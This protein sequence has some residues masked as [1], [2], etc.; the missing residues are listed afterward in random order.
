MKDIIKLCCTP[1]RFSVTIVTMCPHLSVAVS[2][3]RHAMNENMASVLK[4][5]L[6]S[7]Q[8]FL[9]GN[10]FFFPAV[11]TCWGRCGRH[12]SLPCSWFCRGLHLVLS[13]YSSHVSIHTYLLC[14][15][16]SSSLRRYHHS[17]LFSD[18]VLVLIHS[19]PWLGLKKT[20]TDAVPAPVSSCKWPLARSLFMMPNAYRRWHHV[21]TIEFVLN[22]ISEPRPTSMKSLPWPCGG[23]TFNWNVFFAGGIIRGFVSE[24]QLQGRVGD[25]SLIIISGMA[26]CFP[27][28]PIKLGDNTWSFLGRPWHWFNGMRD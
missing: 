13:R 1:L 3:I 18:V 10:Y 16:S 25:Q 19:H 11:P 15:S 7:D 8:Y 21:L 9:A 12:N 27:P 6:L 22:N 24:A 17:S 5:C 26:F 2:N 4:K 14:Y 28:R 20:L 23:R